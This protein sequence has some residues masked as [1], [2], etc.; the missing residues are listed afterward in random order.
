[1]T[2]IGA[3][4]GRLGELIIDLGTAQKYS[5]K[6]LERVNGKLYN[7]Y[8]SQAHSEAGIADLQG[9]P[10]TKITKDN[11][12]AL[13]VNDPEYITASEQ[14]IEIERNQDRAKEAR[15][16]LKGLDNDLKRADE[17]AKNAQ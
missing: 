9:V 10:K 17:N 16:D 13:V 2:R 6:R 1:M 5:K 7:K 14:L 8:T 12:N 11:L 3:L 15:D 4:K